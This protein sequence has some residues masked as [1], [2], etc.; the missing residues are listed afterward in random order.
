MFHLMIHL[1]EKEHTLLAIEYQTE[2]STRATSAS[3]YCNHIE[4]SGKRIETN[5]YLSKEELTND[6]IWMEQL[7]RKDDNDIL[8]RRHSSSKREQEHTNQ[9]TGRHFFLCL[10]FRKT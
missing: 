5:S 1:D 10:F 2:S 4:I 6:K 9:P 7:L 3:G 8:V